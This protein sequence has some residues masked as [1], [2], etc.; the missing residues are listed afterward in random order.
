M[1][2]V[3]VEQGKGQRRS[4]GGEL[5][6]VPMI[7]LL[8]VTVAFLLITAV[9]SHA[10]RIDSAAQVPGDEQAVGTGE[11]LSKVLHV[12]L[13]D[14]AVRLVC[15]LGQTVIA[16]ER[17]PRLRGEGEL[18][19]WASAGGDLAARIEAVWKEHGAHRDESDLKQDRAVVHVPDSAAQRDIVALLDAI[20]RTR[21]PFR[22]ASGE[23]QEFAAMSAVLATR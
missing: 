22:L 19:R 23:R 16:E 6:L 18:P 1:A 4:H 21:R 8:F 3:D 2:G 9:W 17:V 14:D 11:P 15:R 7:D 5:A 12:H 10:S 20:A 13:D